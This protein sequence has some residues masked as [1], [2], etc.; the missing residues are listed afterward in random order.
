MFWQNG[1][2]NLTYDIGSI[3]FGQVYNAEDVRLTTLDGR[4]FDLNLTAGLTRIGDQNGN[5]VFINSN[6]VV[7]SDGTAVFFAKDGAGRIT[8]ITDPSGDEI[9]YTYDAGGNLLLVD[10]RNNNTTSLLLCR[11]QLPRS[12]R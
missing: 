12:H 9:D 4:I 2:D 5:S 11:R 6:G 10:D 8:K 1:S 7:H 3:D